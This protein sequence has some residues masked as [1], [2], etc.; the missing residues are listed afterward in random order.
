MSALGYAKQDNILFVKRFLGLL[1]QFANGVVLLLQALFHLLM[2]LFRF[3]FVASI[4]SC[5]EI[6]E[7]FLKVGVHA[8]AVA[9][10]DQL[11]LFLALA[12]RVF[13]HLLDPFVEMG[14]GGIAIQLQ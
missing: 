11:P 8:D 6:T 9:T 3:G 4:L 14:T 5:F 13:V 1:V 12:S 2:V 10:A 7:I